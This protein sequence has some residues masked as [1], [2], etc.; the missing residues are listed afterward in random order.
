VIGASGRLTGY[1]S[2]IDRKQ[3]LLEHE[4]K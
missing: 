1:A 4:A 2:G 3:W